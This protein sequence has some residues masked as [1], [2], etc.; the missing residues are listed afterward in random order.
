MT[1]LSLFDSYPPP[2]A[3]DA[4]D[5]ERFVTEQDRVFDKVIDELTAGY[6]KSHWMWFV[7]PQAA[8]LSTSMMG[9][10]F[11]IRSIAEAEA[12]W[13]HPV[14]GERLRECIE[15]VFRHLCA[16]KSLNHIFGEIDEQKFRS[17]LALFSPIEARKR[18]SR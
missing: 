1:I 3:V 15:L 18:A 7:F 9:E 16:G 11:A 12:Y 2:A 17:C 14:L 13:E 6:K 8:G 4:F 10:R 5:L